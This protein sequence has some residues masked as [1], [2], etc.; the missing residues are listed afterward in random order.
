[1]AHFGVPK[2]PRCVSR[3]GRQAKPLQNASPTPSSGLHIPI[4]LHSN[5]VKPCK[6]KNRKANKLP[7]LWCTLHNATMSAKQHTHTAHSS[8]N[9]DE[10]HD[11]TGGCVIRA[12]IAG[13]GS[14]HHGLSSRRGNRK[15]SNLPPLILTETCGARK[16]GRQTPYIYLLQS[17]TNTPR[18]HPALFAVAHLQK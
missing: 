15:R 7:I 14:P 10:Q 16:N 3:A 17:H 18:G 12:L 13:G 9:H 11:I 1:M 5:V 6:R 2:G 8:I 4:P